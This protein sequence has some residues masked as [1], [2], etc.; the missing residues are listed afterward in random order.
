MSAAKQRA[1]S[2]P[3][4]AACPDVRRNNNR[5]SY[6]AITG[7]R[8]EKSGVQQVHAMDRG[9]ANQRNDE[10]HHR[11]KYGARRKRGIH[12]KAQQPAFKCLNDTCQK[13]VSAR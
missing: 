1:I 10:E 3:E 9:L 12:R 4:G 6:A 8:A 5:E 11:Q 2:L 13:Y 7:R